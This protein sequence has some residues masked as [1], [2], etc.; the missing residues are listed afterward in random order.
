[1]IIPNRIMQTEGLVTF[2]PAVARSFIFFDDDRRHIKLAQSGSE[3]DAA[4]TATN[5]DTIGL[6]RVA[7]FGSFRPAFFLPCL[8]IVVSNVQIRPSFRRT[9]PKPRAT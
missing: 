6:T 4:L 5:N 2:A 8:L 1:M 9:W 7:E 3:R